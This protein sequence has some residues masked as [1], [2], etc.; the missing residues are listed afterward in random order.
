MRL[1][2]GARQQSEIHLAPRQLDPT[3]PLRPRWRVK[4]SE[5]DK[6]QMNE[7]RRERSVFEC[8]TEGKS[9]TEGAKVVDGI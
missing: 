8:V 4:G 2:H 1:L 9:E 6:K 7:R 5:R 3:P